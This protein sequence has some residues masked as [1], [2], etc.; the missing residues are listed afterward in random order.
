MTRRI[1]LVFIAIAAFAAWYVVGRHDP[2]QAWAAYLVAW[3]PLLA[4]PLGSLALLMV[5]ALTGGAWGWRLRPGLL[6]GA[7][8]LPVASLLMLPLLFGAR[9]LMPWWSMSGDPS[10]PHF[11][12][13]RPCFLARAIVSLVLWWWLWRR[14]LRCVT[15]D[16]AWQGFASVGLIILL[17]SA[18]TTAVD[19]IMS[20][21]PR[22]HSSAIGMLWFTCQLLLALAFALSR[23]SRGSPDEVAVRRDEGSLL[24]VVLLGWAYLVFMDYLTAWIADLPADTVWYLPRL[25]TSWRWLGMV[26]IVAHFALPFCLLLSSRFKTRPRALRALA[27]FLLAMQ[28]VYVIWL[29][30]PGLRPDGMRWYP[31]DVF[32]W[33]GVAAAAMLGWR[34]VQGTRA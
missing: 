20:L 7:A 13:N 17:L 3:L 12:L 34:G 14:V 2:R 11:Y 23:S 30:L 24:L 15:M 4:V 25:A 10:V 27:I 22:W 9:W 1:F 21:V 18:T 5:H 26:L 8:W 31:G 29:V 16:H 32:A 19:W 6:A 33:L 28:W